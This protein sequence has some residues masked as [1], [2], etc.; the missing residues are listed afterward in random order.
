MGGLPVDDSG[1]LIVHTV[2]CENIPKDPN[3]FYLD[4]PVHTAFHTNKSMQI[5]MDQW[6]YNSSIYSPKS[7]AWVLLKDDVKNFDE[8]LTL[9][10]SELQ[11]DWFF[12]KKGFLDFWKGF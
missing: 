10:N 3:W 7:K 2:V 9:I 12:W 1:V 11:N 6:G 4:T 8:T 5:L